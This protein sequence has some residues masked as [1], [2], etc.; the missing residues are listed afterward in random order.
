MKPLTWINGRIMPEQDAVISVRDSGL[1]LGIGLFETMA[2][3][4]GRIWKLDLHWERLSES[5]AVLKIPHEFNKETIAAIAEALAQRNGQRH[6][7]LRLTITAGDAGRGLVQADPA[8]KPNLLLTLYPEPTDQT[9][10]RTARIV[11]IRRF[12]QAIYARHKTLHY[13]EQILAQNEARSAGGDEALMLT[14]NRFISGFAR[15]N[16]LCWDGEAWHTPCADTRGLTGTTLKHISG[17]MEG[18][19]ALKEREIPAEELASMKGIYMVNSLSAIVPINVIDDKEVASG[20]QEAY[21]V[22]ADALQQSIRS[23]CGYHEPG[24]ILPWMKVG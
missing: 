23:T 14:E 1:L 18:K 19:Y 11:T 22:V 8:R 17:L 7:V 2:F 20:K 16:V 9:S 21:Y 3:I 5:C 24:M 4:N 6:G 15:G 13:A 10:D 12:P